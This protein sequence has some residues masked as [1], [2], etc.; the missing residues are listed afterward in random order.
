M[1]PVEII[2]L[3]YQLSANIGF[4]ARIKP[5]NDFSSWRDWKV[6]ANDRLHY[7]N[8]APFVND[9]APFQQLGAN[10]QNYDDMKLLEKI[11]SIITHHRSG[12]TPEVQPENTSDTLLTDKTKDQED[13]NLD[14]GTFLDGAPNILLDP[15]SGFLNKI[16]EET[17]GSQTIYGGAGGGT[18]ERAKQFRKK[19]KIL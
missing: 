14:F 4:E 16:V 12:D 2:E 10:M 5:R 8:H 6:T 3:I 17:D 11:N 9:M 18:K 1:Q 13:F 15:E 19:T 7:G